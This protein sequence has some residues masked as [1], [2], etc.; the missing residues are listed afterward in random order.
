MMNNETSYAREGETPSGK[1]PLTRSVEQNYP[2]RHFFKLTW[3]V[4]PLFFKHSIWKLILVTVPRQTSLT[5]QWDKAFSSRIASNIL[6][7]SNENVFSYS[8]APNISRP[9]MR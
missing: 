5:H 7:K 4:Y 3:E 9:P 2:S 8:V 1:T 6:S